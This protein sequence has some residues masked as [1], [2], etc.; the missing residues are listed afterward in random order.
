[1]ISALRIERTS[2]TPLVFWD[3]DA[4]ELLI[5]GI[6]CPIDAHNFFTPVEDWLKENSE[7]LTQKTRFVFCLKFFNSSSAK[8]IF[9]FLKE[10]KPIVAEKKIGNIYWVIEDNDDFMIDSHEDYQELLEMK[11]EVIERKEK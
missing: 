9:Q 7:K 4:S 8:A 11:I 10:L 3:N 6:C 1:M 5:D 2:T